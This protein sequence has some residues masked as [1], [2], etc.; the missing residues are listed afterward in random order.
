[1]TSTN[2]L[3]MLTMREFHLSFTTLIA[4][5]LGITHPT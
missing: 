4:F 2:T 1:M 5:V 3:F